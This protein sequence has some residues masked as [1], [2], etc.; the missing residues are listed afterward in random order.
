ML[1]W[2]RLSLMH[3][4]AIFVLFGFSNPSL[5]EATKLP[6]KFQ[7]QGITQGNLQR[8]DIEKS[9]LTVISFFAH[10]CGNCSKTMYKLNQLVKK[11]K[12][13]SWVAISLDEEMSQAKGYFKYLP[14]KYQ[15]LKKKAYLDPNTEV[16]STID[17]DSLPAYVIVNKKG[18]V[19]HSGQGQPSKSEVKRIQKIFQSAH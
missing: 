9:E 12:D 16:A 11:E 19:I 1:N 8:R 18:M 15:S 14:K 13:V 7:L 4:A 6:E 10:W 17:V 3:R 5:G 2:T